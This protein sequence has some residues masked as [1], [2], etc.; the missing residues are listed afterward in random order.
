[1]PGQVRLPQTGQ[2]LGALGEVERGDDLLL[3]EPLVDAELVPD[4]ANNAMILISESR[5]RV[6]KSGV[7]LGN[8]G[9]IGV[10]PAFPP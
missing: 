9:F 7:H 10:T 5:T 3:F 1:M 6:I 2:D 4:V 8:A